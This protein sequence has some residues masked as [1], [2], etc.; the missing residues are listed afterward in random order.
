[1]A[2]STGPSPWRPPSSTLCV[3]SSRTRCR[4]H[5][6]LVVEADETLV[7]LL[8]RAG[9]SPAAARPS[10]ISP[11]NGVRIDSE[12]QDD[13]QSQPQPGPTGLVLQKGKRRFVRLLPADA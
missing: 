13:P 9:C 2:Y 3:R 7:D 6:Q 8:E 12:M 5:A 4:R 11:C 10:A 1:M